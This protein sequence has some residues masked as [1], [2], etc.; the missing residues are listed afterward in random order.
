MAHDALASCFT[1]P[2][3]RPS[4]R[5]PRSNSALVELVPKEAGSL[6]ATSTTLE[7]V[8]AAAFGQRRK[9]LRSSLRQLTP[10]SETLLDK[11]RHR[12]QRREPRNSASTDFCRI[13]NA[14]PR[15][16]LGEQVLHEILEPGEPRAAQALGGKDRA[17]GRDRAC[18]MSSLTTT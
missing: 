7:R 1:I 9:M 3:P 13:A 10:D 16:E 14:L 15:L 18:S 17:H 2:A 12:P 6:H 4:P 5:A 11:P 8:T